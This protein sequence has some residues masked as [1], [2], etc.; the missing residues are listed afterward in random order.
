MYT[1]E[2]EEE[3]EVTLEHIEVPVLEQNLDRDN[4]L[5]V[6]LTDEWKYVEYEEDRFRKTTASTL[7]F[8]YDFKRFLCW[9]VYREQ[10][11]RSSDA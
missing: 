3:E 1:T 9:Y 4:W 11:A 10:C 6:D 5:N 8:E 7:E 2:E